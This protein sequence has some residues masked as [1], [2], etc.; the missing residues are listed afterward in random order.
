MPIGWTLDD[1]GLILIW[2]ITFVLFFM[3]YNSGRIR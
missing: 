2:G 3:G 1:I